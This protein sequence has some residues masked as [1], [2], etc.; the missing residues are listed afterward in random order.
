[1]PVKRGGGKGTQKNN[2][3][4][5]RAASR[6]NVSSKLSINA[7]SKLNGKTLNKLNLS[8]ARRARVEMKKGSNTYNVLKKQGYKGPM[9]SLRTSMP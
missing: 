4:S 6:K 1:M 8:I 9:H 7:L 2:N 3:A 5:K